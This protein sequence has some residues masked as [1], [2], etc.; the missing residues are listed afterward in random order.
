MVDDWVL[1]YQ[2]LDIMCQVSLPS[3][4]DFYIVRIVLIA[5]AQTEYL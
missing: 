4:V 3:N 2:V 5:C 1:I